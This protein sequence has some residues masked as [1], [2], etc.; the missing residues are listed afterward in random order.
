EQR[1]VHA[2]E[3]ALEHDITHAEAFQRLQ[4][5]YVRAKET[6]KLAELLER[7]LAATRDPEERVSIEVMRGR[8]LA[9][10]GE[11]QAAKQ[12]LTAALDAN[13]EHAEALDAFAELCK[14]EG[15]W[16][17]AEQA[18]IRLARHVGDAE[19]QAA[20][21]TKLG[22][23][24]DDQLPN[25]ERAEMAYQEV[26]KRQPDNIGATQRLIETYVQLGNEERAV[27]LQQQ[28]I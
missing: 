2:L 14:E 19:R 24:Y 4:A 8:A 27:A 18:W 10:V 13:P 17:G 5:S 23:L 26:L 1:A 6:Q 21:Y 12:A 16:A 25:P 28:L 22:A 15:D 9:G 20:I 3:A 11:K 7:R